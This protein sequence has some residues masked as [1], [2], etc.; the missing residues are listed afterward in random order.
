ML[1]INPETFL[2]HTAPDR[3]CVLLQQLMNAQCWRIAGSLYQ[4]FLVQLAM[5]PRAHAASV[6]SAR[7]G[8]L[9]TAPTCNDR[10]GALRILASASASHL[11]I[12]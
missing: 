9:K 5:R 11:P 4:E 6:T 1:G 3:P 2:P 8:L 10:L 7:P 12:A